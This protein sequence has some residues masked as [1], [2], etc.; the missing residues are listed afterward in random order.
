MH[1]PGE[2]IVDAPPVGPEATPTSRSTLSYV[3]LPRPG[4]AWVKGWLPAIAFGVV[5]LTGADVTGPPLLVAA[6]AWAIFELV[7]YQ[8]RYLVNDLADAEVDRAHVAAATRGRLPSGDRA[9]R[10]A[11]A[12]RATASRRARRGPAAAVAGR[13]RHA[14]RPPPGSSRPRS[15]TRPP[16]RSSA[17]DT[18][19]TQSG[20][21][22]PPTSRW[23]GLVGA[24]YAVR[25]GLGA[26]LAGA[27]AGLAAAT[28][29]YGWAFGTLVVVMTWT[30]EAA[31]LPPG[32]GEAVLA[33]KSHVAVLA[34]LIGDDPTASPRHCWG[35]GRRGRRRPRGGG[36]RHH[37]GARRGA[38]RAAAP[39]GAIVLVAVCVVAGPLVV[40]GRAALGGMGG[41]GRR[42]A[43]TCLVAEAAAASAR[44][45]WCSAWLGPGGDLPH[46]HTGE[47][48]ARTG[49]NRRLD[50]RLAA[51]PHRPAATR[52]RRRRPG[53][54]GGV[55]ATS[56]QVAGE[57]AVGQR[58]VAVDRCAPQRVAQRPQGRAPQM[59]LAGGGDQRCTAGR[60][61][62]SGERPKPGV[63]DDGQVPDAPVVGDDATAPARAARR[64][65][66]DDP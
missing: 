13:R 40:A 59:G 61:P 23:Y 39:A 56:L 42:L 30:C 4:E 49:A 55:A 32:G 11:R 2:T 1:E 41:G 15:P 18:S 37:A 57:Q 7:L 43:P 66:N 21:S 17:G 60:P 24:G 36:R 50:D 53:R 52:A 10:I 48:G 27:S 14:S 47:P 9:R 44:R 64:S 31:G 29:A 22:R 46:V 45:P 58:L 35:A 20:A 62:S 25:I 6:A 12:S 26:G 51:G 5:A 63:R 38:R 33:R 3:L 34:R 8:T 19:T 54:R 28:V 16:A 65:S